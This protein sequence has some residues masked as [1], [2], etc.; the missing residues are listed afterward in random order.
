MGGTA[1]PR[2]VRIPRLVVYCIIIVAVIGGC[3]CRCYSRLLE[4][5]GTSTTNCS[6][7]EEIMNDTQRVVNTVAASNI[8]IVGVVLHCSYLLC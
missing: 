1:G 4:F 6:V 3:V 8:C 2:A 5:S 7:K